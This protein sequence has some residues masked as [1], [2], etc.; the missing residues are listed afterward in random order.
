MRFFKLRRL[1]QTSKK[2][3]AEG[4]E[5]T[6]GSTPSQVVQPKWPD[7]AKKVSGIGRLESPLHSKAGIPF[8]FRCVF[9]G[10]RRRSTNTLTVLT[11]SNAPETVHHTAGSCRDQTSDNHVLLKTIERIHLT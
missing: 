2:A 9:D 8:S 5:P 4:A 3:G 10:L 6:K 7:S 11:G 1:F